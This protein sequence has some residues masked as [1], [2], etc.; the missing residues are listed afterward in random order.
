MVACMIQRISQIVLSTF[1]VL[2]KFLFNFLALCF[3]KVLKKQSWIKSW[4]KCHLSYPVKVVPTV[5]VCVYIP[6]Q[7]SMNSQSFSSHWK[8]CIKLCF[9]KWDEILL[10]TVKKRES[11]LVYFFFVSEYWMVEIGL[12]YNF[13]TK[14]PNCENDGNSWLCVPWSY[15]WAEPEDDLEAAPSPW[16]LQSLQ[17]W[18]QMS[19]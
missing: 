5:C 18:L 8:F 17:K 14:Y 10:V 16:Q 9:L 2:E 6:A 7:V 13:K 1:F 4:I 19:W 3:W 11:S 12:A 15:C